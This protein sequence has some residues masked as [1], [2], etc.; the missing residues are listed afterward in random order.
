MRA[1]CQPRGLAL[2]SIL[3]GL[4]SLTVRGPAKVHCSNV[5][6]TGTDRKPG[7]GLLDSNPLVVNRTARS[8]SFKGREER[9][10]SEPSRSL[11]SKRQRAG[12][13]RRQFQLRAGTRPESSLGGCTV[14]SDVLTDAGSTANPAG[15]SLGKSFRE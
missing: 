1:E 6:T 10:W 15:R 3:L 8:L 5:S 12:A 13:Q 2:R 7:P 11:M 14:T 4:R 9:V